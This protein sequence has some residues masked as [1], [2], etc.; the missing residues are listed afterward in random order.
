M[1]V[2]QT[3]H[4]YLPRHR[5]GAEIYVSRLS[6]HLAALGHEVAIL[7][8]EYDHRRP[9]GTWIVREHDGLPVH[10]LVN[11]WRFDRFES[12]YASREIDARLEA[13]LEEL[14]PDVVHVHS[15]LN[16]SFTLPSLARARG[17]A[18]VATVHDFTLT[19]AAGGQRV[20]VDEAHVCV[21][22]DAARCERCFA[23]SALGRQLSLAPR[24]ERLARS[25][26]LWRLAG[27]LRTRAPRLFAL[28][29][30]RLQK[31]PPRPATAAQLRRRLEAVAEVG[32]SVSL[33]SCPSQAI[34]R[35]L[36]AFG[37]PADKVR[38]SAYGHAPIHVPPRRPAA[39][40]RFGYVGTLVWH[41]GVHL[42]LE[43]ARRLPRERFEVLVFGDPQVFPEYTARLQALARGLPV[44]LA[45]GFPEQAAGEAYARFDVLVVPS[46]WP[47]NAPLVISEAF[48][49]GLPVVAARIGGM[50]ELVVHQANG[51]LFEPFSVE[52]L[53]SALGRLIED[54]ALLARLQAA[55]TPVKSIEQ[56]AREWEQVY[57]EAA[58]AV[59]T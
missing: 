21:E 49:A 42:L 28:A 33:F 12:S 51:L 44:E 31:G 17:I 53:A 32:R 9:Q 25:G 3:I 45:G 36:P 26:P 16:L 14:R 56:D 2:L 34:A 19:C 20:H 48:L 38:V 18:C 29:A 37:I 54:P 23:S 52:G 55:R 24:L 57:R 59:A 15:L 58:A 10:E 43:A 50:P 46:L 22:V 47:E 41:K 4:D 8:A 7:T 30:R 13:L 27:A 5:A 6:R 35:D 40:V 11:N 1:K 39:R